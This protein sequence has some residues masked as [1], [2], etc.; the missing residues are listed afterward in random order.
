MTSDH[1]SGR[2]TIVEEALQRS[3]FIPG[4]TAISPAIAFVAGAIGLL[5]RLLVS[6]SRRLKIWHHLQYLGLTGQTM[7]VFRVQGEAA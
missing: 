6:L 1:K 3:F 7:R 5:H 4:L 2:G